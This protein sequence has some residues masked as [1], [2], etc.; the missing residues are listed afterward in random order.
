MTLRSSRPEN[1]NLVIETYSVKGVKADF[2]SYEGNPF[3][4][5]IGR[6]IG[7]ECK[8]NVVS[9]SEEGSVLSDFHITHDASMYSC[10]INKIFASEV[11]IKMCGVRYHV[12]LNSFEWNAELSLFYDSRG[13]E[14]KD[15]ELLRAAIRET[16][17]SERE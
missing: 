16:G 2:R 4:R 1:S 3:P 7:N 17:F 11:L 8:F 13:I 6:A 12:G 5:R 10:D 9:E 15:L 14:E